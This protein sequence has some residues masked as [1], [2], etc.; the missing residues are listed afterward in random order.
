[1]M[2]IYSIVGGRKPQSPTSMSTGFWVIRG[3]GLRSPDLSELS[4]HSLE[5]IGQDKAR[6]PLRE[7]CAH[8]ALFLNS[9]SP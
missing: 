6:E 4:R 5:S 7:D 1:M 3:F 2:G 9:S 8:T